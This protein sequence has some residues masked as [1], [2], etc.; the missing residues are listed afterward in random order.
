MGPCGLMPDCMGTKAHEESQE[1]QP[2]PIPS[3]PPWPNSAG[4]QSTAKSRGLGDLSRNAG[5]SRLCV[6]WPAVKEPFDSLR[7]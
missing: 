4:F 2:I 5:T 7:M 1:G 6:D 3:G